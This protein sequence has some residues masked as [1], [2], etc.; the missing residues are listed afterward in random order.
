MYRAVTLYVQYCM[1]NCVYKMYS[2]ICTLQ[3][4]NPVLQPC[5]YST[6]CTI[7]YVLYS[8]VT[9]HFNPVC[10]VLYINYVQYYMYGTV[11]TLQYCNQVCRVPYVLYSAINQYVLLQY[12]NPVQ[13]LASCRTSL[14]F[15]KT[16][17]QSFL[18]CSKKEFILFFLFFRWITWLCWTAWIQARPPPVQLGVCLCLTHWAHAENAIE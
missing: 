2:N 17:L 14:S 18:F 8:T 5:M 9:Q 12:C 13:S 7:L 1:C 6:V 16:L 15:S 3:Y 4:W 11:R 10:T